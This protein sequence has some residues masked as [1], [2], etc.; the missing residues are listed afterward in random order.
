ML[1]SEIIAFYS[2]YR[3][4]DANILYGKNVEFLILE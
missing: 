4:E 3:T 1:C 2:D